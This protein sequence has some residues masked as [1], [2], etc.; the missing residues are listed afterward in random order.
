MNKLSGYY[1]S[2]VSLE[3]ISWSNI[4]VGFTVV[5]SELYFQQTVDIIVLWIT[6][7]EHIFGLWDESYILIHHPNLNADYGALR[8]LTICTLS[9]GI[10]LN[11]KG[12]EWKDGF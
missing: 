10:Q 12:I 6:F 5:Q 7:I 11:L 2:Y 8:N 4:V 9:P 3:I 1:F